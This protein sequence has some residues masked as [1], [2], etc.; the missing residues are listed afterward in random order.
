MT[1]PQKIKLEKPEGMSTIRFQIITERIVK[2]L[3]EL[4]VKVEKSKERSS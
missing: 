2:D 4:G 3:E 1:L